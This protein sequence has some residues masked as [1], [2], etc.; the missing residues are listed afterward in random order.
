MKFP[1]S[2]V[3]CSCGIGEGHP[4]LDSP[5]DIML[6]FS[7]PRF[8]VLFQSTA[9][10]LWVEWSADFFLYVT[11]K[12][13]PHTPIFELIQSPDVVNDEH[14][15]CSA[16]SNYYD[17]IA[18][19]VINGLFCLRPWKIGKGHP[20]L[21]SSKMVDVVNIWHKFGECSLKHCNVFVSTF[22]GQTEGRTAGNE[23]KDGQHFEGPR[24]ACDRGLIII[25]TCIL[26]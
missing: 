17:M 1:V 6:L 9:T 8:V 7:Y 5:N 21:N 14:K 4:S 26:I 2:G 13:R 23:W 19:T 22:F 20:A 24:V 12:N 25:W 3:S 10:W 11:L 15:F 18:S 16:I